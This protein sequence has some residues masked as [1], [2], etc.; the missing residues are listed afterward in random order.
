MMTIISVAVERHGRNK[1]GGGDEEQC[2]ADYH[3]GGR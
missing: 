2:Q 1:V 3:D